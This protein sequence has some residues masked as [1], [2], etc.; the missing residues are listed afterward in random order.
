MSYCSHCGSSNKSSS[1][2]C[3][4]CGALLIA[5]SDVRCAI[6]GTANNLES[7]FCSTCGGRLDTHPP[8]QT[9][10]ADTLSAL[11]NS[12]PEMP[13]HAWPVAEAQ[14]EAGAEMPRSEIQPRGRP[15]PEWISRLQPAASAEPITTPPSDAEMPPQKPAWLRELNAAD[16]ADRATGDESSEN[17]GDWLANLRAAAMIELEAGKEEPGKSDAETGPTPIPRWF[18]YI[19][20]PLPLASRP[21]APPDMPS[22]AEPPPAAQDVPQAPA[23]MPIGPSTQSKGMPDWL[24]QLQS[25]P[26]TAEQAPEPTT[27][28]ERLTEAAPVAGFEPEGTGEIP[29]WVRELKGHAPPEPPTAGSQ[30]EQAQAGLDQNRPTT[31]RIESQPGIELPLTREERLGL[32]DWLASPLE[33]EPLLP[34][35]QTIPAG[36]PRSE[37]DAITSPEQEM[38]ARDSE[39]PSEERGRAIESSKPV[40]EVVGAPPIEDASH[41]AKPETAADSNETGSQKPEIYPPKAITTDIT[42]LHSR[43]SQRITEMQSR[44]QVV[45]DRL[46]ATQDQA[47]PP[48]MPGHATLKMQPIVS[49]FVP[50]SNEEPAERSMARETPGQGMTDKSTPLE[51]R[52]VEPIASEQ[53]IFQE[54][55]S[56][57]ENA[58]QSEDGRPVP[59]EVVTKHSAAEG[60]SVVKGVGAQKSVLAPLP[61]SPSAEQPIASEP[62]F[63]RPHLEASVSSNSLQPQRPYKMI[64]RRLSFRLHFRSRRPLTH[65]TQSN[66]ATRERALGR[67]PERKR[68]RK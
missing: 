3:N 46:G 25:F 37:V 7:V 47:T 5:P 33:S 23:G 8:V 49:P 22:G 30:V 4:N 62:S 67:S 32:P 9:G 55:S 34:Q 45:L 65:W 18:A 2:F 20:P 21:L 36:E 19:R 56:G 60:S 66:Q 6:C 14:D 26:N 12:S 53:M 57:S 68:Q 64:S 43:M 50:E 13:T 61:D 63:E 28:I 24:V 40:G 11:P 58:R 16:A 44:L 42:D 41:L 10:K 39:P 29:E 31:A 54:T 15:L 35:Q 27:Q 52:T 1:K 48:P 59:E 17:R 38:P 51:Q